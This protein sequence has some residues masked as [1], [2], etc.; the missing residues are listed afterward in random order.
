G[1]TPKAFVGLGQG[2][3]VELFARRPDDDAHRQAVLARELEVAL[4]VARHRHD[5]AR[6]VAH[7]HEVA[8]PDGDALAAERVRRVGPGEDAFLLDLPRLPRATVLR[9]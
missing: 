9:A 1:G 3:A 8:D 4:V 2:A 5:R 6:A 7:Q